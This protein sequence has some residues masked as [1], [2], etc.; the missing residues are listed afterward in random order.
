MKNY[1][2]KEELLT[3]IQTSYQRFRSEFDIIPDKCKNIRIKEIDK[4]PMEMLS[5]QLGWLHLLLNWDEAERRGE[6]V[7]TPTAEYKWNNLG[8]LYQSFYK[9]YAELSIQT[10]ILELNGLV[11]EVSAWAESLTDK[12]LMEP[13]Q[14]KWATTKAMWPVVKWVHINTVEPFTNFRPKIRKWKKIVMESV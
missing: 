2:D 3:A 7:Q 5:Y 14:R 1:V 10:A 4:T 8:G 12:E 9:K 11:E 13:G 6:I